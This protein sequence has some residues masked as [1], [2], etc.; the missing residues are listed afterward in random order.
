MLFLQLPSTE[1]ALYLYLNGTSSALPSET[2]VQTR[3]LRSTEIYPD[4]KRLG[5]TLQQLPQLWEQPPPL[6]PSPLILGLA[7][8]FSLYPTTPKSLSPLLLWPLRLANRTV[9]LFPEESAQK[10]QIWTGNPWA[11]M[12]GMPEW[13][14]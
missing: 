12:V 11:D 8:I 14:E 3:Q 13:T 5:F 1:W 10:H 7:T 9:D 6:F 4:S 2:R